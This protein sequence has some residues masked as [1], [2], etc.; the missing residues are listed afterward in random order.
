MWTR[1]NILKTLGLL[2]L[3]ITLACCDRGPGAPAQA[4]TLEKPAMVRVRVFNADGKLIGPIEMPAVVKT[5]AQWRQQLTPDQYRITRGKDT[6]RPFCG[7]LLD[8][9]QDGVYTCV[10]CGLP[11]FQSDSKFNSGTGWPSF[12]RPIA[13][14]NVL[15]NTDA[16][17]G[18]ERTEILCARCGAHL[19]HVFND[20]PAPTGLRY[21]LNSESLA[22]TP[23]ADLKKLADPAA[24][25]PATQPNPAD[26]G[27]PVPGAATQPGQAVAVFAGGCFWCTQAVFEQVKGVLG[28]TSGYSGGE[29]KTAHYDTVCSGT[30]RHAE[31]IRI[32]YDP[33]RTKYDELLRIFFATHDPTQLNG[34]GPDEGTQYRSAVF[35]ADQSQKDAAQALIAEFTREKVFPAPIVTT[36]EPLKAFYPAETYHQGYARCHPM[37]PYILYHAAPKVEKLHKLFPDEVQAPVTK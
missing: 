11:L 4:S 19:G 35:Y 13:K 30:T 2:A 29:A 37:N 27:A 9:H 21:C 34:Q 17:L 20:G 24:A 36:L 26:A 18:M 15:E 25:A 5:D 28:V 22:F 10:D 8:N 33:A 6:E 14:E 32:V 16:S 12:F 1:P 7:T 31:A 3:V 23:A